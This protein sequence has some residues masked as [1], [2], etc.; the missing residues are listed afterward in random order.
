MF[1]GT[2]VLNHSFVNTVRMHINLCWLIVMVGLM[3]VCLACGSSPI[4]DEEKEQNEEI[5]EDMALIPAGEFLMGSP[6]GGGAFD[7][8]PE[9]IVYLDAYYVDKYEVTNGQFQEFVEATEY[10]TDAEKKGSGEVWNPREPDGWRQELFKGVNWK[11]PN[12]WVKHRDGTERYPTVWEKYDIANRMEHPV[13]QV[14]RNDAQVYCHWRGKRLPTEAEWEKAARG[15]KGLIYPWGDEFNPQLAS[16]TPYANM[17]G[18]E[19]AAV[20]LFST[21]VSSYGLYDMAGNVREWVADWYAFDYYTQSPSRNPTGPETR[22][23][24]VLR[25][26]SW[27]NEY[28]SNLRGTSRAYNSPDYSS[29]FVG[30]RCAWSP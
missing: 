27:A 16:I 28:I 30:F 9:H 8:H 24:R 10:V 5:L 2:T 26:G 3:G 20:G 6:E 14:S 29:N 25:G 17:N 1:G 18:D 12:A 19:P 15:N 13:A 23:F 7:E 11:Q 22:Q 21:D 4:E